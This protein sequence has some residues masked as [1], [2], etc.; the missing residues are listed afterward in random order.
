MLTTLWHVWRARRQVMIRH[1]LSGEPIYGATPI[2]G[3]WQWV[4]ERGT[5][6]EVSQT[7]YRQVSP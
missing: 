4:D 6:H 3:G 7:E 5:P 2:A 1:V